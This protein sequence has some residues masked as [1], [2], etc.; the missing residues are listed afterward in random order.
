MSSKALSTPTN[1]TLPSFFSLLGSSL[2]LIR[3]N[4]NAILGYT[5]WL[6]L[7]II[8]HI[9]IRVTLGSS[10]LAAALDLIANIAL[11]ITIIITYNTI[12]LHIPIWQTKHASASAQL[13]ASTSANILAQKNIASVLWVM[14]IGGLITVVGYL[15]VIPG[16]IFTTWFAFATLAVLFENTTGTAALL[17]SRNLIRERFWPVF[18]RFW[19]FTLIISFTYLIITGFILLAFGIHPGLEFDQ[20]T[21]PL[22]ADSLIKLLEI[23]LFPLIII[24]T[25][26]LY[27]ALKAE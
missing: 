8:A 2:K 4:L 6:L 1:Q 24:Y 10:D 5:G 18:I 14:I 20:L 21:P 22:A 3:Q 25:T 7:P 12:V 16:I 11:I 23:T 19:S 17:S 26:L 13:A 9:I 27:Q 15:L